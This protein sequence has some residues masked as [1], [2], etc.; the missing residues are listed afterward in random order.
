MTILATI[1]VSSNMGSEKTDSQRTLNQTSMLNNELA[2]IFAIRNAN[3]WFTSQPQSKVKNCHR[4]GTK[5]HSV[6]KGLFRWG[7]HAI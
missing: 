1:S 2:E 5:P 4:V 3:L 7:H 6:T